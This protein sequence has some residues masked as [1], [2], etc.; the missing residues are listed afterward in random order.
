M[1]IS[2]SP[3]PYLSREH[4]AS[5]MGFKFNDIN[6]ILSNDMG[7][8]MSFP[9]YA[10]LDR[11]AQAAAYDRHIY[12]L[13]GFTKGDEAKVTIIGKLRGYDPDFTSEQLSD[14]KNFINES[15]GL[16]VEYIQGQQAKP[17]SDKPKILRDI[18]YT[19]NEFLNEYSG[20]RQLLFM[21]NSRTVDLLD[22]DMSVDEFKEEWAKYALK[23]RFNITLSGED[24]KNAVNILKE[25]NEKGLQDIESVEEEKDDTKEKK[26]TP[27]QAESKNTE[28]YDITKDEKFSYLL[29]LQELERERG[30]DVLRIMQKLEENGKK[31]VD[32]KV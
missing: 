1:Q 17:D 23:E 6:E 11:K 28:T 8:G 32:K 5:E 21:Q 12:P 9:K 24:A 3:Y 7:Y 26:F 4:I 29:K 14:L 31:V 19:V 27:I 22:S 20:D 13:S 18:P 2:S 30:I 10:R 16:F 15:K 25:M